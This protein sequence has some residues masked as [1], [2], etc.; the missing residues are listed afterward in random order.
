MKIDHHTTLYGVV[1]FLLAHTLNPIMHNAAIQAVIVLETANS[2]PPR[3]QGGASH[4]ER[5]MGVSCKRPPCPVITRIAI[6]PR[7]QNR[8]FWHVIVK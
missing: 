7:S 6:H 8:A 1:G 3:L 4:E 5:G 2:E